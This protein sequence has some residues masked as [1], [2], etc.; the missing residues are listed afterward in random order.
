ML[1]N[2]LNQAALLRLLQNPLPLLALSGGIILLLT[3]LVTSEATILGTALALFVAAGWLFWSAQDEGLAVAFAIG[4]AL[5][6]QHNTAWLTVAGLTALWM[7]L[8]RDAARDNQVLVHGLMLLPALVG[9][10]MTSSRSAPLEVLI[11]GF[12]LLLIGNLLSYKPVIVTEDRPRTQTRRVMKPSTSA[13]GGNAVADRIRYTVDGMVKAAQAIKEMT[14]QQING[15]NEQVD[16]IH[17]N[18]QLLETFLALSERAGQYT[19]TMTRSAQEAEALSQT[20]E[21]AL[22]QAVVRMSEIRT[23]VNAIGQTI[24]TLA[25]LTRSIDTIIS[26]VSEIA[27]QSNLLALNASI[28]AARAGVHGRGFAVVADEVR[29]LAQQSTEAAKQ[30]RLILAEIQAAVKE[31]IGAAEAGSEQ[32][33]MGTRETRDANEAMQ[34]LAENV[35]ISY[36]IIKTIADIVREQSD[37]MEA[38]AIDMERLD[39]ITGQHLVSTRVVEQVSQ[40]LL[41]LADDLEGIVDMTEPATLETA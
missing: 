14:G 28:E 29:T 9:V 35:Q 23:Q 15:A 41:R 32:V 20:G 6:P 10:L 8:K 31:T 12:G 25:Q 40:N 24:V 34:K 22:G 4:L 7:G 36:Q 26:S 16:V 3:F 21:I 1:T 30:V 5:L 39:R 17:M 13:A 27:T 38:V 33:S 37:G 19:R 2:R 11:V 18:N